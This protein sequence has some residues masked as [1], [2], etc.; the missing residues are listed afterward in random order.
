MSP[1]PL[2][3]TCNKGLEAT[4][5]AL[6]KHLR[7]ETKSHASAASERPQ[8]TEKDKLGETNE[9]QPG[10]QNQPLGKVTNALE[11]VSERKKTRKKEVAISP[12][13]LYK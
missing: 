4:F 5:F 8:E 10:L 3:S 1:V 2:L 12:V 6:Q 11:Y 7:Q 13:D 9:T